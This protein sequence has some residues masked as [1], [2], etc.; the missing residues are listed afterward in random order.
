MI[1][2]E[3]VKEMSKIPTESGSGERGGVLNELMD[4]Y[5]VSGLRYL[6]NDQAEEF[7]RVKGYQC[8]TSQD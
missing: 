4:H 8:T 5:N 1:K 7:M 3:L 2:P 6:S